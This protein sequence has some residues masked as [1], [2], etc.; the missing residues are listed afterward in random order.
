VNNFG[1]EPQVLTDDPV[2]APKSA[3]L[4]A[5]KLTTPSVATTDAV[6]ERINGITD[7]DIT[8]EQIRAVLA[9]LNTTKAGLPVGTALQDPASGNVAVRISQ[10]GLE[11][12]RVISLDG[13]VWNDMEPTLPWTRLADPLPAA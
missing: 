5:A 12:W 4:D 9:A 11:M 8:P 3:A 10:D 6:I 7:S 13:G 2:V 1:P